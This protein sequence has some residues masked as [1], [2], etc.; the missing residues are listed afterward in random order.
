M[1]GVTEPS[2]IEARLEI[3]EK[4]RLNRTAAIQVLSNFGLGEPVPDEIVEFLEGR[5]APRQCFYYTLLS[6]YL[7]TLT[8][9]NF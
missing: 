1:H 9:L 6:I 2:Q 8:N 3:Y 7:E 5:P 4:V